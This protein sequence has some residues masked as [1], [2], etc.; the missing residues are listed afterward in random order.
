[1]N[2]GWGKLKHWTNFGGFQN[3]IKDRVFHLHETIRYSHKAVVFV[4]PGGWT[5]SITAQKNRIED[6]LDT[7]DVLVIMCGTTAVAVHE[8]DEVLEIMFKI[9]VEP[10]VTV[11]Q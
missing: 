3:L 8:A 5:R 11:H 4:R 10:Q 9:V 6:I 7:S 1:M 2:R